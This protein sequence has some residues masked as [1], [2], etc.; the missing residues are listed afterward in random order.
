MAPEIG[1]KSFETFEEQALALSF[2]A[3][4]RELKTMSFSPL[5]IFK[6]RQPYLKI[7]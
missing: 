1:S 3:S 2:S 4:E 7:T 6:V 5:I